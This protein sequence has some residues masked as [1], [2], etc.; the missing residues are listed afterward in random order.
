M[1]E[2]VKTPVSV[3][4]AAGLKV[5]LMVQEPPTAKIMPQVWVWEKSPLIAMP[6]MIRVAVPVFLRVTLC[7]LLLVPTGWAP[8]VREEV[9]NVAPGPSPVPARLAD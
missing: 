1:S 9:E 2:A 6:E 5:T 8:N 7:G 3:P 4:L